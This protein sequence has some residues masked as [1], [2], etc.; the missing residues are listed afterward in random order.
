MASL[1]KELKRRNVFRVAVGYLVLAWVV[2]Q[3]TDLVAPALLLPEWTLSLVTFLGILGFPFALF[4]AW[5]F[6]LTPQGLKRSEDV[7][8]EESITG[9]TAG[10]LNKI[11]IALLCAA[12]AILLADK[13]L[14]FGSLLAPPAE[15][16]VAAAPVSAPEA[17]AKPRSIAVLPFVNMSDDPEQEYFSDG[18]SEEL[19]N[20]LAKIRELRV[21]ARTSSFAF[22]DNNQNI[23]DI[24]EQLKVE[25]VLEGSV[26]KSGARVRITAQLISVDDGYHMWSETY[27]RDLTDIF[28]V[29][30]EISAAIVDALKLHLSAG[31]A[32][33][34]Q[35]PVNI[36]AYNLYLQGRHNVRQRDPKALEFALKQFQQAID[37]DP[38]YAQPWAGMS[39]ATQLLRE[40][41]YGKIP[42]PESDR[43][44][45]EYLDQ[46]FA[47]DPELGEAHAGQALLYN[48]QDRCEQS[49]QSL[50]KALAQLP[51]EGILYTWQSFCLR[52]LGQYDAAREAVNRG[53]EVDPLHRSVR[54]NWIQQQVDD[55]NFDRIRKS[56]AKGT[57]EYYV[58]EF[59]IAGAEGRRADQYRLMDAA[60][61]VQGREL[62][63]FYR[64]L[65]RFVWL[66]ETDLPEGTFPTHMEDI[67]TAVR[68]PD[69][70]ASALVGDD[71][72]ALSREQ[73]HIL[74]IA[75]VAL[76]RCGDLLSKLAAMNFE[77]MDQ[78]GD[79]G[80]GDSDFGLGSY[81]AHCLRQTGEVGRAEQLAQKLLAYFDRAVANGLPIRSWDDLRAHLLLI[82]NRDE[83]A[84]ASLRDVYEHNAL[85]PIRVAAFSRLFA[86]S[87]R[88]NLDFRQLCQDM[89]ATMNEERAKLGWPPKSLADIL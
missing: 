26:R 71:L 73:L 60:D 42:G 36:D 41:S 40:D 74:A 70:A 75:L 64:D 33:A 18:I 34:A 86:G 17:E 39:L 57:R 59:F 3:I 63:A 77:Q 53:F 19:L 22:K 35:Q 4:F 28:A 38:D 79:L 88:E 5:A 76:D 80:D 21:A 56:V 68:A 66:G 1:L 23:T 9:Q 16:D 54:V 10:A 49:L 72:Q 14:D 45:Q 2:M 43:L 27:D 61:K 30:D 20:A 37:I 11:T 69:I 15:V 32:P 47:L 12:V 82:L 25:T 85:A 51:A 13:Y 84:V 29:Q 55:R 7:T 89:E 31:E 48:V 50:D 83:E 67:F 52:S 6:E 62:N 46:A 87:L 58:A 44:A 24:G 8:P 65:V 81:Y 78:F